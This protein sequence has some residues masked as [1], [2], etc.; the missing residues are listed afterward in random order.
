[1]PREYPRKLRVNTQLQAEL[2]QLIRT[3]LS[4]PRVAGVTVTG[5][6]V[7]P[8]MRQAR[9]TVSLLGPDEQ[10]KEAVAG[11]NHAAGKLRHGLSKCMRLRTVPNL[12]FVADLALREGDRVSGLIRNAVAEDQR[13]AEDRDDE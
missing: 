10:L 8:D 1:M 11:L 7:A 3:E 2:A 5:V 12:R 9:V 4:D 13:H 6:D